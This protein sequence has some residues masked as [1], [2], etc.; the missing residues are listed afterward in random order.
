MVVIG[1]VV[2]MEL[3]GFGVAGSV[4]GRFGVAG[5]GVVGFGG[6]ASSLGMKREV[7]MKQ[8]SSNG[9]NSKLFRM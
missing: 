8:R 3:A 4:F 1:L 9:N 6:G 5:F 7:K 2:L